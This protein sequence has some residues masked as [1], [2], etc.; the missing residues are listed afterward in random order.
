[1]IFSS[2]L[3]FR[4]FPGAAMSFKIIFTIAVAFLCGV[5]SQEI[6]CDF[7]DSNPEN[8]DTSSYLSHITCSGAGVDC[9]CLQEDLATCEVTETYDTL[10]A[11]QCNSLCTSNTDCR[12]YKHTTV[13]VLSY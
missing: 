2:Q 8:C 10:T 12:F 6:D 3:V 1:M 7:P 13:I 11:E 5:K 4:Q 9:T